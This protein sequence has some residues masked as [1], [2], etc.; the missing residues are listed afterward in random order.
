MPGVV[1]Q[2]RYEEM[3]R[4]PL[5]VAQRVMAHCGLPFEPGCVDLERNATPS[6]TASSSQIREPVHTRGIGAWRRYAGQLEGA[7]ALLAAALP[8]SAFA[9]AP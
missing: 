6:A 3:V 1:L 4:D 9:G 2:V 5:A 8:E 7:R